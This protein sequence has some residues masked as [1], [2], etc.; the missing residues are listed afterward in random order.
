MAAE[1][2]VPIEV[3]RSHIRE[4]ESITKSL[5]RL[6]RIFKVSTLVILLRFWEEGLIAQDD[7]DL[8]WKSEL[9]RLQKYVRAGDSGGNFY[10]TTLTRVSPRFARALVSHTLEG[11]TL[12]RD[13]FRMLGIQRTATF[14]QLAR[15]VGVAG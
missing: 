14:E 15:E 7:F 6:A 1:L 2:L 10:R 3:L 12:Y 11:Q 8:T 4:D 9:D 13:A 5:S